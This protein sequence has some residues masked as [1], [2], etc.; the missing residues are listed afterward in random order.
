MTD[1]TLHGFAPSTYT[2]TARMAAIEK[3]VAHEL[4]PIAYGTPEH[5][6]LHPF[7]RMPVMTHGELVLFE[8]LAIVSYLDEA[9]DGPPLIPHDPAGRARALGAV[10]AAIDYGYRPLV[11]IEAAQGSFDPEQRAAAAKLLDWL[12]AGLAGGGWP[13]GLGAA[14]LFLA[15]MVDYH[16]RQVGRE[17]VIPG[18]PSLEAWFARIAERP[19]FTET[20]VD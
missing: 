15:P 10:S 19:S 9:F 11:Q 12:D 4:V 14:D 18:R 5:L 6:A 2:R 1:I 17:A 13:A 3:G 16:L 20:A 7:G 8:T